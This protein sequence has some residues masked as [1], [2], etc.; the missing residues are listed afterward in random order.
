V[1]D[2][3]STKSAVP[4]YEA[5]LTIRGDEPAFNEDGVDLTQVRRALALTPLE[6]LVAAEQA[7]IEIEALRRLVRVKVRPGVSARSTTPASG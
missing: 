4:E 1:I 7:A 6:R 3:V 2:F 5:R